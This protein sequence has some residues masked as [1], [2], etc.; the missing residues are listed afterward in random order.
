MLTRRQFLIGSAGAAAGLVLPSWFE[1]ALNFIEIEKRPLIE[2]PERSSNT[3][4]AL[5]C[6]PE[7]YQ[8]AL[9]EAPYAGPP[10]ITWREYAERYQHMTFEEYAEEAASYGE[11]ILPD[12][13]ADSMDYFEQWVYHDSSVALAFTYLQSLDLGPEFGGETSAGRIDFIDGTCPGNDA[14]LAL[15]PDLISISLLQKRLNDLNTGIR[16]VMG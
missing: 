4:H 12:E 5:N 14:R 6:G 2:L 9:G 3:L 8:L 1:R 16:V 10:P 15:A 13:P 11:I 7:G